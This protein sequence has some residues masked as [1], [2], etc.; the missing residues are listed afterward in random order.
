MSETQP[1]SGGYVEVLASTPDMTNPNTVHGAG[2]WLD[3]AGLDPTW[4]QVYQ[5]AGRLSAIQ[6]SMPAALEVQGLMALPAA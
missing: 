1:T 6:P 5:N 2:A 4:V 3:V